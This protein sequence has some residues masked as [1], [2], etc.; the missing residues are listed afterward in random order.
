MLALHGTPRCAARTPLPAVLLELMEGGL[1][2]WLRP[3]Y[4]PARSHTTPTTKVKHLTRVG[5][6]PALPRGRIGLARHHG[7]HSIEQTH[8]HHQPVAAHHPSPF[9]R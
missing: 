3:Q 6:T 4:T 7:M 2:A 9:R 5:H 8:D 1:T